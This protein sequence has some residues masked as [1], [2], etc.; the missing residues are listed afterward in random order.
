MFHNKLSA[1]Q[2]GS[3]NIELY[4][5]TSAEHASVVALIANLVPIS[6]HGAPTDGVTGAGITPPATGLYIDLDAIEWYMNGGTLGSP[7]WKQIMRA[8]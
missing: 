1:L 3:P 2:G 7:V 8:A 5:L 4:H 6:G